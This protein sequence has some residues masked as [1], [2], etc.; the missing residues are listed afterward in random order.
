MSLTLALKLIAADTLVNSDGQIRNRQLNIFLV[1][2]VFQMPA[3]KRYFV[4]R[5]I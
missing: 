3:K 2:A 4:G 1:Y 5:Q